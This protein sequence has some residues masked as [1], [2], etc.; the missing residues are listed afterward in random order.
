MGPGR[1]TGLQVLHYV[2]A[3]VTRNT[4]GITTGVKLG[5]LPPGAILVS[6]RA[7]VTQG[8]G[9][10]RDLILSLGGDAPDDIATL[11]VNVAKVVDN[12]ISDF[13]SALAL[14]RDVFVRL[15]SAPLANGAAV[16]MLFYIPRIG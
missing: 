9:G 11:S 16:V 3:L 7:L 8:W 15:D 13:V 4:L 1:D 10:G 5:S 2:A 6:A 14:G 12:P